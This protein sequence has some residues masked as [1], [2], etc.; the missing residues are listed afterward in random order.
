MKP[1]RSRSWLAFVRSLPCCVCGVTR[2]VEAAHTG[3]RGLGQRADDRTAIPL[4][5]AHHDRRKPY[6]IHKLGPM[7]FQARY[8]ID[9]KAIVAR[10]NEKPRI[11]PDVNAYVGKYR[12]EEYVLCPRGA[13]LGSAIRK[14]AGIRYEVLRESFSKKEVA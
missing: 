1:C 5:V 13:G 7:K 8:G 11:K 4:C 12:D 3:T 6:S 10:L 2:G 14:M 9:I